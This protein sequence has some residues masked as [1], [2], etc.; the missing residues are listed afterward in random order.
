MRRHWLSIY[1]LVALFVLGRISAH[2]AGI[3][4]QLPADATGF[5]AVHNLAATSEKIERVTAIFKELTPGPLPAPLALAKG[6]T[7]IGPG[8]NEQGDSLLAFLPS[9]DAP[10]PPQPLLLLP[11]SDYAAL[12]ESLGGDASGEICRVMISGEE[13][14]LAK[15]GDFA[16]LMN[17]EHRDQFE[18]LLATTPAMPA[19]LEPLADW[20]A[21]TDVFAS[22]TRSGVER[23]TALGR[24]QAADWRQYAEANAGKPDAA[25]QLQQIKK[26]MQ[27]YDLVFE[28]LGAEIGAG[29]I[30]LSIDDSANVKLAKRILLKKAGVLASLNNAK[31]LAKSPLSGFAA[32][33]FVFAGGGPIPPGFD[34]AYAGL[35][36]RFAEQLPNESGYKGFTSTDWDKFEQSY[37]EKLRGLTSLSVVLF[38]GEKGDGLL[39]DFFSLYDTT[40]AQAYLRTYQHS[41]E[42]DNE[43][44]ARAESDLSFPAE[45]SEGEVAG[46]RAVIAASDVAGVVADPNVPG[47]ELMMKTAFGGDGKLRVFAV[48]ADA[49]T[50]VVGWATEKQMAEAVEFALN[51]DQSLANESSVLATS[52]LLN[53]AAPWS[54]FISPDGAVAWAARGAQTWAATFGQDLSVPPFPATSPIGITLN[55]AD[56]QLQGEIVAPV[57]LLKGIAEYAV[58]LQAK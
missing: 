27:I 36:R 18:S 34:K 48:A 53:P 45:L 37:L 8:L 31:P 5:V 9:A 58:K 41:I 6:V 47:V 14:L 24:R 43:L 7:G 26:S 28:F 15:R 52:K 56:G 57:D 19:E 40:D 1:V 29:V 30:G 49:D 46:K 12:A 42:L 10:F 32:G 55:L 2:G 17:V 33:P 35:M 54:A 21:T 51:G 3:L 20:L 23:L 44:M 4:D 50:A 13:V 11:V 25:P 39:T 38:T 22:L 16:A